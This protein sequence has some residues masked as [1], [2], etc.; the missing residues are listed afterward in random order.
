VKITILALIL[1]LSTT[2]FASLSK[3][4]NEYLNSSSDNESRRM[5]LEVNEVSRELVN[6][7]KPWAL[8]AE[9]S[10]T[11][12]KLESSLT[13]L[14]T[15][16]DSSQY[17]IGIA[18]EFFSGTS[19]SFTNA[20]SDYTNNL[21][22]TSNNTGFNQKL[23][24]S[25]DLWKNF[26]G[27]NDQLDKVIAD[28]TYKF[29]EKNTEALLETNLFT[30]VNEYLEVKVNIALVEL[31]KLTVE[32]AKKRLDLIQR[33]VRDGLSEK[34]DLFSAQTRDLG[35]KE[36]L[37]TNNINLESSL[38]ALSKRLHRRVNQNEVEA[39]KIQIQSEL[40]K[41]EGQIEDNQNLQASLKQIN[42]LQSTFD[43][44]ENSLYPSLSLGGSYATN[45]YES[46]G[47]PISNGLL[48]S[49]NNELAVGLTLTWNVGSVTERLAKES[50]AISLNKAK[51]VNRKQL[52]SLK[53]QETFLQRRIVEVEDL[54]K[55][56]LKRLKIAE[57]TLKEYNRLYTRGRANLDQVIRAE[58]DLITTQVSYVRYL[59]RRDT[60]YASQA[61]LY[62]N[63]K[64]AVFK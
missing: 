50:S 27:R 21:S 31:Q 12:S 20:L 43:Q 14:P 47:S 45:N 63:L 57:K 60:Y 33:R 54:L 28:E 29:Q 6:E 7:S 62:G 46:N 11:S 44:K 48:G 37:R 58:E 55:T 52:L 32:R 13:Q 51:M 53:Q 24:L 26:L 56:A 36:N 15:D 10:F 16:S 49:G 19:L 25:Q 59:L 42:Y 9:S 38:E 17:E 1:T 2:T 34:V 3:L 23:S 39:Y 8:S 64:K 5:D 40:S 30:F 18:K 22:A 4:S 61:Y 35:A 41:V